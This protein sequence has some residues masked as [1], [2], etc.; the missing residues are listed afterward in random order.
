MNNPKS[1]TTWTVVEK[2]FGKIWV[3][4]CANS[5]IN[6]TVS[7][8]WEMYFLPKWRNDAEIV[9]QYTTMSNESVVK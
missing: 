3:G 2:T 8:P 7:M 1:N 9:Y 5:G 6:E 4:D